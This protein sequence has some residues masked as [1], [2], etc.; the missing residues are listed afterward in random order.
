MVLMTD[1]DGGESDASGS[2]VDL[3]SPEPQQ[4]QTPE[5]RLSDHI[6]LSDAAFTPSSSGVLHGLLSN[7]EQNDIDI[8]SPDQGGYTTLMTCIK[9]KRRDSALLLLKNGADALVVNG[10]G[11]SAFHLAAST[12]DLKVLQALVAAAR[13]ASPTALAEALVALRLKIPPRLLPSS[14]LPGLLWCHMA[15]HMDM[16]SLRL[17]CQK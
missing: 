2:T 16:A 13:R 10:Q 3:H 1:S 11:W 14:S 17:D 4:A 6:M 5:K 9:H 12:G 15:M 8:N 7:R